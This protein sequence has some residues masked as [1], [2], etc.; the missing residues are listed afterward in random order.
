MLIL[1]LLVS[2]LII[3]ILFLHYRNVYFSKIKSK[4]VIFDL[5]IYFAF[6]SFQIFGIVSSFFLNT[7]NKISYPFHEHKNVSVF[8]TIQ[9]KLLKPSWFL[10]FVFMRSFYFFYCRSSLFTPFSTRIIPVWRLRDFLLLRLFVNYHFLLWNWYP[11]QSN[12]EYYQ[13][14]HCKLF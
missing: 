14:D 6:S 7:K 10:N 9:T 1:S 12:F 2:N 8:L 13:N 3:C 4:L 5:F 11:K